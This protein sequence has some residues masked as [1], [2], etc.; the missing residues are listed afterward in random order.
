[1]IRPGTIVQVDP[2]HDTAGFGGCLLVVTEVRA[3]SVVGYVEV[4]GQGRTY[5]TV[6]DAFAH[7]TGGEALWVVSG[8]P[9]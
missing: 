4:P 6:P 2:D 8:E 1:M 7:P 3:R 9:P 5:H